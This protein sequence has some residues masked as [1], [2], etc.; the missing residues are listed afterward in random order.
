MTNVEKAR[1][2]GGVGSGIDV[3]HSVYLSEMSE[4]L[5]KYGETTTIMM[6]I[7][8]II[9]IIIIIMTTIMIMI[10]MIGL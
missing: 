2:C 4:F 1:N 10:M 7:I 8:I 9:I 5:K 6:M 3:S